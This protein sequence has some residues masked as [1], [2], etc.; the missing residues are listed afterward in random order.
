MVIDFQIIANDKDITQ[1]VKAVGSYSISITDTI[2]DKADG[3]SIR[4]VDPNNEL[5][6]PQNSTRLHVHLGYKDNLI[7][8]GYF[9]VTDVKYSLTK[10]QGSF[11]DI[12]ASSIPF[13]DS[14]K[15]KS[16]QT[17]HERSFSN[18]TLKQIVDKIAKE[19]N[20]KNSKL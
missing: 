19:H 15:Y 16:M 13:T 8:F 3:F 6:F 18:Q 20:L 4:L 14:L 11:I 2:G 9:F 12:L 7:D 10:G 5:E 1:I 17:A